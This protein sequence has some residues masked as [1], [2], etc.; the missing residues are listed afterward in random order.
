MQLT[1]LRPGSTATRLVTTST[2]PPSE[3]PVTVIKGAG[4]GPVLLVTGGVHGAEYASIEAAL[5][6]GQVDPA[7]L[8]GTLIVVP[9]VNRPAF[10]ARS[11]YVN[12]IDGKNLNRVFPG[13]ADGTFAEQLADWLVRNFVRQADAWIDLHGGDMN[14]V[15]T[16]FTIH[17]RDNEASRELAAQF[18]IP[19]VVAS[20]GQGS[21]YTL[22]DQLGIPCI[23]AEASGQGI[24]REPEIEL[25]RQGVIRVMQ[26]RKMLPGEPEPAHTQFF[27]RFDVL[28]SD[29]T[30]LWYLEA[31][32]GA[33]VQAGARLGV[34]KDL[35][36]TEVQVITAPADGTV[37]YAV[38]SLA[39]NSGDPLVGLGS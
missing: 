6:L 38:A 3:I 5:R 10:A 11:I 20:A 26:A 30:G 29:V 14:E 18:G 1:D 16:P 33:K 2:N 9:I 32:M 4:E 7:Q 21:S 15:L 17:R 22:S 37:L 34:L 25:L 8:S 27:S 36:G 23:I 39:I 13:D 24:F 28:R 31:A 19:F 12:P 35:T